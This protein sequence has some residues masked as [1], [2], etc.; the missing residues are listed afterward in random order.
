MKTLPNC[1]PLMNRHQKRYVCLWH[2]VFFGNF[3]TSINLK[4]TRIAWPE[5][6]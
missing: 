5:L 1:G 6:K 2:S 3:L 4:F